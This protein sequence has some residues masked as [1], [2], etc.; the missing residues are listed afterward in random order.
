MAF[1]QQSGLPA[2][3]K[4]LAELSRLVE[5]AGFSSLREARHPLD[6]TQRQANGKF[7]RDEAASLIERLESAAGSEPAAPV[8]GPATRGRGGS[9]RA[10]SRRGDQD[11]EVLARV[12]AA[13]LADELVRRGWVCIPGS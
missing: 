4:D 5:L 3:A 12:P 11:A 2:S 1:G 10:A 9:T 13:D 6:L 7:T 8:V